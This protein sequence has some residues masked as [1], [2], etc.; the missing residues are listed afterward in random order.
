MLEVLAGAMR[1]GRDISFEFDER[2]TILKVLGE[3]G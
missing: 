3:T 2:L 1:D